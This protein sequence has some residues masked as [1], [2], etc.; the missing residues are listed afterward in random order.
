[1]L[2]SFGSFQGA[3]CTMKVIPKVG[4][5]QVVPTLGTLVLSTCGI[6]ARV[7]PIAC[8]ILKVSWVI[9]ANNSKWASHIWYFFGVILFLL[10]SLWLLAVEF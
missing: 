7:A 5:Y 3:F 10:D 6:Q 2:S 1:M 9:L 8:N 4:D